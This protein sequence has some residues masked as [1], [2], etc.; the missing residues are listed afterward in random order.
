MMNR[1]TNIL[2]IL[3]DDTE[4]VDNPA[5][6]RG[7]ELA[8]KNQGSLTIMDVISPPENALGEYR[9]MFKPQELLEMLV[10]RREKCLRK[11]VEQLNSDVDI[12]IE[13]AVGREFIEIIRKII[14]DKHDLLIKVANE[15]PDSFD[16]SDFHLMRKCPQPVWL[17]KSMDGG[18][19]KKILATIDLNLESQ[20]EGKELNAQIMNLATSLAKW[21]NS[22]LHVLSC[23]SLYGENKFRYSRFIKVPEEKL[24]QILQKEE[25]AN[26]E[27]QNTLISRYEKINI[28]Q[29]LLKGDPV[30]LIPDFVK[31]NAIDVTIM[32]TVARSGIPGLLIGNTSETILH[33]IDSSVITLKPSGF[34][35]IIK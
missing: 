33:L 1:F 12:S 2:V 13:V 30:N 16:S 31:E 6:I 3:S 15:H 9:D 14:I 25:Q 11:I 8:R 32:G 35:S 5:L 29:H 26:R 19:S 24:N 27:L 20:E 21:E 22:E 18:R 7:H 28:H 4:S 10:S 34:E 23:W 17:L